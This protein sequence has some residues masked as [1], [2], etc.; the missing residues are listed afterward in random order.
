[1]PSLTPFLMFNAPMPEVV[2]FYKSV[3]RD[4]A[5]ILSDGTGGG[6]AFSLCGQRFNAFNGGPHFSFSQGVSFMVTVGT[7]DEID[8]YWTALSADG[9]K[10]LQCGWVTDRFGL[11]WQIVPEHLGRY[12][13][14]PDREKAGR[15]MQAMMGM[16]KLD[17]AGL[18][19][20]FEGTAQ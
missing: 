17:I 10:P 4:D 13:S 3:F 16:G 15:A 18:T 14:D 7:Q 5:D 19:T 1:M 11:P 20:A 2:T 12:L 8:Y 6:A 9:G